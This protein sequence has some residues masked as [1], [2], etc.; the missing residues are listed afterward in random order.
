MNIIIQFL[1]IEPLAAKYSTV[2]LAM[3]KKPY[4]FLDHRKQEYDQDY[5]E[6]I[7]NIN[8]LH[9]SSIII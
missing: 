4:E 6:F 1:G 5:S 8:N 7:R 9:V 3:K 2:V